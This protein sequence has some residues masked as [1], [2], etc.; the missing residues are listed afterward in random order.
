MTHTSARLPCGGRE[1][2]RVCELA[3][4]ERDNDELGALEAGTEV[5]VN[6]L[7]YACMRG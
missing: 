6:V 3:P 2:V 1:D 4:F 7:R 5:S